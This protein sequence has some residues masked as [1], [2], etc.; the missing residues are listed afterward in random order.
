MLY[1]IDENGNAV[2]NPENFDLDG[3]IRENSQLA[4]MLGTFSD[5]L[6]MSVWS[7]VLDNEEAKRLGRYYGAFIGN[8]G[9]AGEWADYWALLNPGA[10]D[11]DYATPDP[12]IPEGILGV[13]WNIES[14]L[15]NY[16]IK[17][18]GALFDGFGHM[19]EKIAN[20]LG[21]LLGIDSL[22]NYD[23][24]TNSKRTD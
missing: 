4:Q 20:G 6:G 14:S 22:S 17:S 21:D 5:R 7:S 16:F 11:P 1:T 13:L 9:V 8:N 23:Y 24:I 18:D 3:N 12:D 15:R 19:G 10:D 2:L